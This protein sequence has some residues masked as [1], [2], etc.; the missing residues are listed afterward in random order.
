[1]TPSITPPT[2][3]PTEAPTQAPG[4]AIT[5]ALEMA[6][7]ILDGTGPHGFTVADVIDYGCAGRGTF[8]PFS[9]TL[10]RQI[11][12]VDKSFYVWKK[13]IQCVTNEDQGMIQSY[14]FNLTADSCGK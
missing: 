6:N 8:D 5:N 9:K 1:M 13:C 2:D 12:L 14:D 3:A 11:D 4:P 10:G 7:A